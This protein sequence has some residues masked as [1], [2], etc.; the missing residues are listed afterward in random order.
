MKRTS[1]IFIRFIVACAR[2]F[3]RIIITPVTKV[4]VKISDMFSNNGKGFEKFISH[5]QSLVILSLLFSL[6]VF[7]AID[8][9]HISLVNSSAEIL[10]DIPVVV[11]YNE[12]L[13]VVEGVPKAADITLIGRNSDVY[14]AKQY[15]IDGVKLDLN[16]LSVGTHNVSFK[17]DKAVSSVKYKIDPSSVNITIYDKM[18]ETRELSVDYINR[19][20][21]DSKLNID[22]V[23]LSR[24]NVIVKGAKHQLAEVSLIKAMIDIE[25]LGNSKVGSK[26][27]ENVLLI[28]YDRE[29]N[30]V[31]IEIVPATISA[32]IKITSPSKDVPIKLIASGELDGK[33]IKSLTSSV[34]MVTIYGSEAAL[35]SVEFL[36]VTV[37]VS[38]VSENRKYNINLVK[39]SGVRE[40]SVKTVEVD[41]VV[42]EI[43]S[44]DI[45]DIRI[46][47][48]NVGTGLK[49][50]ALT[51][52]DSTATIIVNGS[53]SVIDSLDPT[54]IKAYIDVTGL[55][56]GE[57]EVEVKVT[58]SDTKITYASRVKKV[59]VVISKK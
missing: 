49:V 23:V 32:T 41:L 17:Y 18:Y 1:N 24:D 45:K 13:Y 57:H 4:F 33:S 19:D 21:L 40:I 29:G 30:K 37:D 51:A 35:A 46:D 34:S 31:N 50:S 2:F 48:I 7:Y 55:S 59:K 22:S 9:K 15:P 39:P 6:M 36:P 5:R 11:D 14:L 54:T 27:L 53:K 20:R 8:Q 58:G 43:V 56:I 26:T 52:E 28:A 44:R 12:A 16:G 25:N 10:Y 3:D 47:S 38:G 42:D